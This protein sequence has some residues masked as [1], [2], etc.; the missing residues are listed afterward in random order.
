MV[1]RKFCSVF[2]QRC[3]WPVRT[4]LGAGQYG[5]PVTSGPFQFTPLPS[6]AACV[7]GGAGTFP[8]EQPFLLP[9]GFAQT[10]IAREGDGGTIDNWDMNTLNESGPHAGR[11]LLPPHETTE[12][13]M[14]SVTDLETGVTSVLVQSPY[15]IAWTESCG[16]RGAPCCRPRRCGPSG[17]RRSPIR[18]CRR[19][20]PG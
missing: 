20:R 2:V 18:G 17:N 11:F 13:G 7:P 8:T 5:G 19:L 10:V 4:G 9:E 12:N 14:V 1:Q 6:S 3:S 16:P 15:W